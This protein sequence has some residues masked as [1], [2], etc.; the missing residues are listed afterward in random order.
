M[1]YCMDLNSTDGI[2]EECVE[3]GGGGGIKRNHLYKSWTFND[4]RGAS[5]EGKKWLCESLL[6][7]KTS[8]CNCRF[9][10]ICNRLTHDLFRFEDLGMKGVI[11]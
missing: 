8:G 5:L 6:A 3:N 9:I 2:R 1:E 11:L 7:I 4:K 10:F